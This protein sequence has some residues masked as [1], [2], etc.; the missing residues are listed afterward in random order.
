VI[1][2]AQVTVTQGTF[3]VTK[4]YDGTTSAGT[5]SGTLSNSPLLAGASVSGTP[6]SFPSANV[7][8][9]S[10]IVDLMVIGGGH[11][12]YTLVNNTLTITNATI[13]QAAVASV[14]PITN[15]P[16]MDAYYARNLTTTEAIAG[17]ALPSTVTVNLA[18]GGTSSLPVTWTTTT[19]Y[20]AQGA[21]YHFTGA[22]TG[23]AN[24]SVPGF[25]A[26]TTTV[27]VTPVRAAHPPLPN[28]YVTVD[29]YGGSATT[30]N[31]GTNILPT[32][33][34]VTVHSAVVPYTINW[35]TG[36][37]NTDTAGNSATFSGTI[38]FTLPAWLSPPLSNSVS[39]LVTVTAKQPVTISGTRVN[40]RVFDNQPFATVT[41]VTA[42]AVT[43]D[44]VWL[45]TSTDGGG[46]SSATAPTNA[47]DYA[48]TITLPDTHPTH[49]AEPFTHTF[50]IT[51]RDITLVADNKSVVQGGT[52]PA[53]TFTVTNLA[54]GHTVNFH[55]K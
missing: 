31:L 9:H 6:R 46:Y 34:N 2:P 27:T 47:G 24:V 3:A 45:Y 51:R 8:T 14:A 30:A 39:R 53:L 10:V 40:S 43:N 50:S 21:A 20:N 5:A 54:P 26:P 23:N 32:G 52:L 37:L 35:T 12:N 13:T 17:Y 48:L 22:L 55:K 15:I 19:A 36:T 16:T 29:S 7:G 28:T 11:A 1:A 4:V 18:T 25:I 38:A 49:F 41:G 33:G 44:L 42:Q